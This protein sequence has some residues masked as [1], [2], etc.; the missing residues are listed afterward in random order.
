KLVRLVDRAFAALDLDDL[1]R[2]IRAAIRP[3]RAKVDP[4]RLLVEWNEKAGSPLGRLSTTAVARARRRS[5][6]WAVSASRGPPA[7]LIL[8]GHAPRVRR[9]ARRRRLRRRRVRRLRERHDARE[10]RSP[11]PPAHPPAGGR[12]RHLAGPAAARRR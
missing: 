3:G 1:A 6:R 11:P 5:G 9:P 2:G 10:R 7:W 4:D 8:V 12:G